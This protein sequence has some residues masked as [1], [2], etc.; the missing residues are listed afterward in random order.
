MAL[1]LGL[2]V[3][4][5][6]CGD[7][8]DA[9][10]AGG[11][12]TTT[13][14]ASGDP[15]SLVIYSGRNEELVGPLIEQFEAATGIDVEIRYGDTAEMAAQIL[16]E[17]D[18]SPADV[19][20]GQDAGALGA[21][22]AEG[23]LVELS[24][25]QLGRVPT[26]LKDDEGR[27]VGTSGRARV[28]AY[29]TDALSEDDLPDSILD[30]TDPAWNGRLGWAPTNGSFQAFVTALR[31]LE[32]ED[33]ARAWLEGVKANSPK[34]FDGNTAIVEAVGAGEID[35]G[36][37][38]HYYLFQLQA[39]NPDLPVANKIF[40]GGD[41][42][43]LVNVAGGGILDTASN[44]D[45]AQQFIDFLLSAE[46][47]TYFAETTYEIPLAEGVQPVAGVPSLDDLTLPDIDLNQLDD[48]AGTLALLTELGIV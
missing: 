44:V 36:F 6:A 7:D 46:A 20:F 32:G 2:A 1:L 22:A 23:R 35:A 16:E 31:V 9:T 12:A 24:D 38:N 43:G 30:F 41:P 47:Q 15:G 3:L 19:F 28:V 5:A 13:S 29:N 18:N 27:W 34:V 17:G 39:Q 42:G 37:V 48:L 25:E 4:A 45:A 26:G 14:A 10:G 11:D 33:G 8:D 21:L 40:G